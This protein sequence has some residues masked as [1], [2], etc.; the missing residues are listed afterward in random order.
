MKMG[1][2]AILQFFGE[3][4]FLSN[5]WMAKI[6]WEGI[7]W[8]STEHAYQAAKCE[9][10]SLWP[11]FLKMSV[12]EVKRAGRGSFKVLVDDEIDPYYTEYKF[13]LRPDWEEVKV[14]IMH[15]LVLAKFTQNPDL[16]EKLLTTGDAHLEEGN[17]WGD[18]IW[19]VCPAG[20]GNGKNYLGR[21]LMLVRSQLRGDIEL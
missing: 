5:F 17:H 14:S 10:R 4:R 19:G 6:K 8:P 2:T 15:E 20:S 1:P 3:Y 7:V 13:D 16:A 9:D 21:I 11:L 18:K 12:V